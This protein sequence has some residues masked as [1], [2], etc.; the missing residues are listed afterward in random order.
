[1][2]YDETLDDIIAMNDHSTSN[3]LNF[4]T[5]ELQEQSKPGIVKHHSTG[6][7][8]CITPTSPENRE[9]FSDF[10]TPCVE[11]FQ[12]QETESVLDTAIICSPSKYMSDYLAL[13]P[14]NCLEL[15]HICESSIDP[16]DTPLQLDDSPSKRRST[17]FYRHKNRGGI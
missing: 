16:R 1:M 12:G 17:Q 2:M 9:S 15:G 4:T 7:D 3:T 11:K 6:L 13:T 8:H 5:D 14:T 10:D